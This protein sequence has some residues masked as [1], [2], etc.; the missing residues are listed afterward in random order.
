MRSLTLLMANLSACGLVVDRDH[1]GI[2]D[3]EE[4]E[5]GLDPNNA[6][7]DGDGLNDFDEL[8]V[9]ET[10]P[11]S[12]DT[13]NDG[14]ID[15]MEIEFGLDPTDPSSRSYALGWPMV[16]VAKKQ[17]LSLGIAP[18]L[19]T[20]GARLRRAFVYDVEGESFDIYDMSEK[21]FLLAFMS[22]N[23]RDDPK[24]D[25]FWYW[26]NTIPDESTRS[27]APS[28]WIRD[29]AISGDINL[30]VIIWHDIIHGSGNPI[31]PTLDDDLRPYCRSGPP[32]VGCFADLSWEL[33]DHFDH[34]TGDTWVLMDA[35]MIVRSFVSPE[36][37]PPDGVG[38][39]DDF[40]QKLSIMLDFVP[41]AD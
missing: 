5:F 29:A 26:I 8:N 16:P 10:N 30:A 11:L 14:D 6:D 37:L 18:A 32:Q 40:E 7:T 13:D 21:P 23:H 24:Q 19:A 17:S 41:P 34:P 33:Y 4:K 25:I 12:E 36:H 20:V 27:N 38:Y 22:I 15:S 1:D 9:Y 35:N 3:R 28:W 31:P 39:Y 2:P